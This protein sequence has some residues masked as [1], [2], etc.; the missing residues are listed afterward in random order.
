MRRGSAWVLLLAS[1]P[2]VGAQQR[3][4]SESVKPLSEIEKAVEEFKIQTR[5]LGLRADSPAQARQNGKTTHWHGRLFEN[6]RN[7]YLDA[8]PHEISQR[9]GSKGLLRRNQFGFNIS[10]PVL[11]PKLYHGGRTTFFTLTYEGM[12]ETIARTFLT[13]VPT[14]PE[15][16]GDWA[17]TVDQAGNPLPVYD[18]R[19]TRPNPGFNPARAV[20]VD[21]LQYLREQFPGNRIPASRLDAV[22]RRA[23]EF[24]PAPNTS[25]GPFFR[26]NFYRLSPEIS[27]ADGIIARVDHSF[28]ERHRLVSGLT[29]SNGLDGAPRL[30]DT[31]ANP[32]ASDRRSRSRR[33]SIEHVF[34]ASPRTVN[35]FTVEASTDQSRSLSEGDGGAAAFPVYRISPYL[36]M[37]RSNPV[38]RTA[39][40]G[41]AVTDAYSLRRGRHRWRAIGQFAREQ[42]NSFWPQYPSGMFRFSAGLTSL[43]GIVNTGHPFASYLLGLSDFAESSLVVSPSYFRRSR[44]LWRCAIST[45]YART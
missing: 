8:V 42:V 40:N 44:F 11:L 43:P 37:G 28:R 13:T 38:S 17:G 41:L 15:R 27:R 5:S 22:S 26:N 32:G 12:R 24:Y 33:A 29:Y 39:R 16:T 10:G 20:S 14:M 3:S 6:F 9:G 35:T 31:I 18:P 7:D 1:L 34:T 30:F 45:S 25:V 4:R 21:N 23:L 2:P 19:S 36:G